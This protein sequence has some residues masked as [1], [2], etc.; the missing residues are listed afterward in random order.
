MADP[1]STPERQAA[2]ASGA[3]AASPLP[4]TPP[5]A[6]GFTGL[7]LTL[8]AVGQA[9]EHATAKLKETAAAAKEAKKLTPEQEIDK[10]IVGT[11]HLEDLAKSE[12]GKYLD[13]FA[14]VF[15]AFKVAQDKGN[16]NAINQAREFFA[17]IQPFL[18]R[19][20]KLFTSDELMRLLE[21]AT[22]KHITKAAHAT[23]AAVVS[24][25]A[26]GGFSLNLAS[27]LS[28]GQVRG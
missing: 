10:A 7:Y 2:L 4:D 18:Q 19:F 6:P 11:R 26:Q 5:T 27:L 9:A 16:A 23:A 3:R 28:T 22:E 17:K 12:V 15:D 1:N 14:Q 13:H 8:R 24:G 25:V 21:K 20:D